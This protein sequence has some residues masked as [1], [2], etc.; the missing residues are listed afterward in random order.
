MQKF[1][2]SEPRFFALI[3]GTEILNGRR[4]D[5]HFKFLRD[6]LKRRGLKFSGSFIIEDD[7]ALIVQSIKFIASLP[8]SVLFSFGGIGSTP[9]DYTRKASSIAL[10]DGRLY[11]HEEAK[12]IIIDRLGDRAYPYPIRMA[13]LPKG[14][15]LLH[16]PVNN[17]PA[18]YLDDRYFFMPGFPQMSH[19]MVEW[20][21][22]NIFAKFSKKIYRK[23]LLADCR[24]S[25]IID[26]ME[27][28]PKSVELS[29][30]PRLGNDRFKVSISLSSIEKEE[31]EKS[32]EF[33]KSELGKRGI[34]YQEVEEN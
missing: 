28:L 6:E 11:L 12:E 32:F 4:E 7:P 24:E 31:V 10:R 34:E 9:D 25:Q 29:S 17:M 1:Q 16:N 13:E 8:N 15:K 2:E 22:D 33:F 5:S 3:I 26:I 30:L 21:L 19:P 18:Y 27:S 14:A 20:A 23:T